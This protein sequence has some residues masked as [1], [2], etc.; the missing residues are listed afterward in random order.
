VCLNNLAV[1]LLNTEKLTEAKTILN[2]ALEISSELYGENA[3][4]PYFARCLTN[5]NSEVHYYLQNIEEADHLLQ[6][7]LIIYSHVQEHELI[8]PGI[9][10]AL[11]IKAKIYQFYKRWDEMFNSLNR[12]KKIAKILYQDYPHPTATSILFYLGFCEQQRRRFSDAL[13]H[14]QQY[15]KIHENERMECLQSG[16]CCNTANVL[17]H[18][19]NLHS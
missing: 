8:E 18:I 12:A 3:V 5:L 2:D 16:H 14:Y 9:I 10:E 4:H 7:A 15:L 6:L 1:I 17:L 11:I 13:N 19:A